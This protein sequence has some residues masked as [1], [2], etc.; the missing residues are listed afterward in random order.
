[1]DVM[2]GFFRSTIVIEE[3]EK[4]QP[5][6]IKRGQ[7]ELSDKMIKPVSDVQRHEPVFHL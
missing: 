3:S 7:Q 4:H 6:H 5:E 1:M 2:F